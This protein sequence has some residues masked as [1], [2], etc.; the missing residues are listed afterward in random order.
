[1]APTF[2]KWLKRDHTEP[3]TS[4]QQKQ[5]QTV[6]NLGATKEETKDQTIP[7]IEQK[8]EQLDNITFKRVMD[9]RKLQAS[10][11]YKS[12]GLQMA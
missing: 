8:K 12:C 10:S 3:K 1:M 4:N 7:A 6:N 11:T 5:I 9:I 2:R